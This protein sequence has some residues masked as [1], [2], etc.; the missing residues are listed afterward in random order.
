MVRPCCSPIAFTALDQL[1]VLAADEL[2]GAVEPLSLE[3]ADAVDGVPSAERDIEKHDRGTRHRQRIFQRIGAVQPNARHAHSGKDV[4]DQSANV[5]VVVDD[6]TIV[7]TC[8]GGRSQEVHVHTAIFSASAP[9]KQGSE[10]H[11]LHV[12]FRLRNIDKDARCPLRICSESHGR[13]YTARNRLEQAAD[14]RLSRARNLRP[15]GRG[16]P[17]T[18]AGGA[19]RAESA[20]VMPLRPITARHEAANTARQKLSDPAEHRSAL[21][22]SRFPAVRIRRSSRKILPEACASAAIQVTA[23]KYLACGRRD[24][25]GHVVVSGEKPGLAIAAWRAP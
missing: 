25:C 18:P 4:R 2:H 15:C 14:A 5:R 11:A 7:A 6:H 19:C 1:R 8:R 17:G 21:P 24:A 3:N 9:S 22:C 16:L 23:A 20:H 13:L 12:W 10:P